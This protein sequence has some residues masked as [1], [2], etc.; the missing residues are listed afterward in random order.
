MDF[1]S[2]NKDDVLF[3]NVIV[4]ALH[5]LNDKLYWYNVLDNKKDRVDV[6]VYFTVSGSE[7]FLS[8]IFL[9]TDKLKK[10]GKLTGVYNK[11]PRMHLSMESIGL[12]E[13][14]LANKFKR[15]DYLKEGE[16]G[17]VRQHNAE[18]IDATFS[19]SMTV[20]IFVD[21]IVDL[22]KCIEEVYKTFYKN[23][24]FY[25]DTKGIKVPC[26][27]AIPPDLNKEKMTQFGLTDKKEISVNF[28]ID[29]VFSYPIFKEE[30]SIFHGDGIIDTMKQ[31]TYI[32][33]DK[34]VNSD[35]TGRID[36]EVTKPTWPTGN[37]PS[38]FPD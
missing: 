29:L 15:A 19:C 21:S 6:P 33:K 36:Y 16:D 14:Y 13:E 5:F 4:G 9:N 26:Y 1:N 20:K 11:F 30:T 37:N 7:R 8:D 35:G 34:L 10:D 17:E 32:V 28:N 18:F 2:Q 3:R 12:Q 24:Y 31:N 27:F 38:N 23:Q 22:Y 25:V